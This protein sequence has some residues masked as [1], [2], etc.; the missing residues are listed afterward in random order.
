[1]EN[2]IEIKPV[3][4]LLGMN[5]FIPSYQR[6]YRWTPQ[7]VYDLLDDIYDFCNQGANGIYCLQPLAV[8]SHQT[9]SNDKIEDKI[10]ELF[11]I[12][13]S[14]QDDIQDEK[15]I[16][17]IKDIVINKNEKIREWEV[18]DGQQRLTTIFFLLTELG[19]NN[20]FGITYATHPDRDIS[21]DNISNLSKD[22]IDFYHMNSTLC[23]IRKW[24][25]N[26][27][28][29][30]SK[31]EFRDVLLNKTKFIWYHSFE[32]K[33][34]ELFTRLNVGKIALTNAE[35]VKALILNSSN[36]E[37]SNDSY[38]IKLKQLEIALE[39]ERIE[40]A[41]RNEEFWRFLNKEDKYYAS[42]I[43]F[44]FNLLSEK[45][46]TES[47][48]YAV[49]RTFE[50]Q[51][52]D[53]KEKFQEIWDNVRE[54]FN[55]FQEWYEDLE[56]YHYIGFLT[57][58]GN[59]VTKEALK[60]WKEGV[61]K[62]NESLAKEREQFT[63]YLKEEIKLII[64]D[65]FEQKDS[66]TQKKDWEKMVFD[67]SGC[68]NKQKC[69]PVLLLHN[70]QTIINN[71]K[72]N[73]EKYENGVFYRFPFHIYQQENWDIEHIDSHIQNDISDVSAQKDWLT[74]YIVGMG[75][76]QTDDVKDKIA[77]AKKL[78]KRL[79]KDNEKVAQEEFDKVRSTLIESYSNENDR[80][81]DGI[82]QDDDEK[83]RIWN[84][85]LL[86]SS[87]NRGYGNSIFPAKRRYIIGKEKGIRYTVDGE[88]NTDS[89]FVP[90]CTRNVFLK[91][92]TPDPSNLSIW[93][94]KDAANYQND[95]ENILKEFLPK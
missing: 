86:D 35:L 64:N 92:Y 23:T 37:D 44:I 34:I 43:D 24:F 1:M 7:Q 17:I 71:N 70:L 21:I 53:N 12:V 42:R 27:E 82:T 60:K 91:T 72:V 8:V 15:A 11:Q 87:T 31:D 61:S 90:P 28:G 30:I 56:L 83:D 68:P 18:I 55:I 65:V 46:N 49:F 66:S 76:E 33:P 22:E 58:H 39:W 2:R 95:I 29:Q 38:G 84:F 16:A 47:D 54:T 5:F 13:R 3:K 74:C 94:K 89:A 51:I 40:N 62:E 80:L 78:L 52:K 73:T 81:N 75:N 48:P 67:I 57:Y 25:Q 10:K 4:E 6:G 85:A 32:E 69:R 59:N 63:S 45:Q 14:S 93:S 26:K 79:N 36:F 20:P 9:N 41:L 50:K 77:Q 88:E 19:L